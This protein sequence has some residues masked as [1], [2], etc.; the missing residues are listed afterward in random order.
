MVTPALPTTTP[1]SND[2]FF[3]LTKEEQA[4]LLADSRSFFSMTP[5]ID[6]LLEAANRLKLN[7]LRQ[8]IFLLPKGRDQAVVVIAY[9]VLIQLAHRSGLLSSWDVGVENFETPCHPLLKK[10][11]MDLVSG[12]FSKESITPSLTEYEQE[13][14]KETTSPYVK[15]AAWVTIRRTDKPD[16][17]FTW[18]VY[19]SDFLSSTSS[20]WKTMPLFM[21]RKTAISQGFR[22]YFPDLF[23]D[24]PYT[25]DECEAH[26]GMFS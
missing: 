19:L 2:P 8:Q 26:E 24:F 16:H 11:L 22:L 13:M 1:E 3:S 23:H 14:L 6:K 7:P 21:L 25:A 12:R 17:S 20:T 4:K 9:Q 15:A 5:H 18:R 10:R